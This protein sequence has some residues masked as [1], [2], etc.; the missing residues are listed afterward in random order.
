MTFPDIPLDRFTVDSY[1]CKTTF[2]RVLKYFG[3][4]RGGKEALIHKLHHDFPEKES[5]QL[6]APYCHDAKTIGD[7]AFL[8]CKCNVALINVGGALKLAHPNRKLV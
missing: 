5:P 2:N 7:I 3:I 4:T 8:A 1:V 6:G